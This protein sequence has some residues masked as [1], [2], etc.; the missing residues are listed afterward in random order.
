MVPGHVLVVDDVEENRDLLVR[1]LTRL[2]HTSATAEN[3]RQ[4]LE[5]LARTPFDLVLLDIMMPELNGFEVLERMR[6]AGILHQVPVIVISA[7]TDLDSVVKCIEL[8]ADDYLSKP[9][10]ATLLRARIGACLDKKRFRDQERKYLLQI[11]EERARADEL[12]HVILPGA[13]VDELKR[14]SAV[15][16]RRHER[17]A[18]LFCDV[19]GFTKYCDAHAPEEVHAHLQQWVD[20]FEELALTHR[21]EKIKTIGDAFMATTGLLTPLANPVL[22]AVQCGLKMV[23]LSP[24]LP[25][26][27]QVR[28]GIHVGPVVAGVVGHRQYLF[29]VWGDT[30]NTASRVESLG[31]P[32]AVNLSGAAWKDVAGCCVGTSRGTIQVK[33]KGELEMFVVERLVDLQD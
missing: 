27:W 25:S 28:V 7:L 21:L 4:A 18:V 26:G 2:G 23:A 17:V 10:N 3:G 6:A 15:R 1:R 31:L 13:V 11:E 24:Q 30:V 22:L 29:D 20:L 32:N 5:L 14:T 16:P 33:G 9:F 19:V 12:L 8:G